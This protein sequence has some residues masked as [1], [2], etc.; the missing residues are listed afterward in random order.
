MG[1]NWKMNIENI[2][3]WFV[4]KIFTGIH[5]YMYLHFDPFRDICLYKTLFNE[6]VWS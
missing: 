6:T 3:D 5:I 1:I 2:S 4:V